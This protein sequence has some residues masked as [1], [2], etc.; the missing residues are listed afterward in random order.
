MLLASMFSG[1]PSYVPRLLRPLKPAEAS[2]GL[3]GPP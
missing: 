1:K 3:E 2:T